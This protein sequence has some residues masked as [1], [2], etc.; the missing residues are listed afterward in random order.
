MKKNRILSCQKGDIVLHNGRKVWVSQ[1]I[2][3]GTEDSVDKHGR[4]K[5]GERAYI[6]VCRIMEDN[7]QILY[8]SPRCIDQMWTHIKEEALHETIKA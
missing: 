1:V 4:K 8:R 7:G 6:C 3:Q 2:S 5:A